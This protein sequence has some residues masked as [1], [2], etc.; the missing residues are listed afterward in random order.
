[1]DYHGLVYQNH[2]CAITGSKEATGGIQGFILVGFFYLAYSVY[3]LG[4]NHA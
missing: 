4:L 1:M 2:I 3:R